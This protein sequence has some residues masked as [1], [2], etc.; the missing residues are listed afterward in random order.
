MPALRKD[1]RPPPRYSLLLHRD[2]F[3]EPNDIYVSKV[4]ASVIEDMTMEEACAKTEEAW[5]NGEALLRVYPQDLAEERC[6]LIRRNGVK[7]TIRPN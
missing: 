1:R 5:A 3:Q 7:T 2:K 6:E 4:I